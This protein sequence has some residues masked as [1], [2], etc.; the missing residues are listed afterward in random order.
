MVRDGAA[1]L[2][3]M[4]ISRRRCAPPHRE[5]FE[6]ALGASSPQGFRNERSRRTRHHEGLTS[7]HIRRPYPE[8][9]RSGVSKDGYDKAAGHTPTKSPNSP[10][11]KSRVQ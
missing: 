4:R 10:S 3:T 6:T 11:G 2:L 9:P 7:C 8:E 1:R 5:D